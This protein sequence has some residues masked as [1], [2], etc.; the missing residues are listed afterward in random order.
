MTPHLR[1]ARGCSL[2]TAALTAGAVYLGTTMSPWAAV[3]GLYVAAFL[4]WCAR[5][6]YAAHRRTLV[7]H[8]QARLAALGEELLLGMPCCRLPEHSASRAHGTNCL[9]PPDFADELAAACCAEGFVSRGAHHESA[10]RIN[11][12]RS[13]AA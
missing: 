7:R 6:S 13:S 9:R 1:T 3:P 8:E 10:C 4:G 5:R 2:G 11:S 12:P